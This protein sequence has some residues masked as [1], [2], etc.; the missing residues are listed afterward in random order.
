MLTSRQTVKTLIKHRVMIRNY[1]LRLLTCRRLLCFE[2]ISIN[3]DVSEL[4]GT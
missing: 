2:N 1:W 4:M 3:V